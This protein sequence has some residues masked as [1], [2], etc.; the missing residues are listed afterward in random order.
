MNGRGMHDTFEVVNG[1]EDGSVFAITRSPCDMGA[2]PGC[3]VNITMDPHVRAMHARMTVVADG[4][5]IR[6]VQGDAIRVNG[7]RTGRLFSRIVRHGGTVQ[8]GGTLLCLQCVPDGLAGRSHGLPTDSDAAW[9][10]RSLFRKLFLVVRVLWRSVRALLNNALGWI[11]SL[12]VLLALLSFFIPG[13][14]LWLSQWLQ[15]YWAR[16]LYM[17]Q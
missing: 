17:I 13:L 9:L 3:A 1:P 6:R 12:L 4:Y 2:D 7:R 10:M 5:R 14:R 11:V 8:V 16:L 15:Y